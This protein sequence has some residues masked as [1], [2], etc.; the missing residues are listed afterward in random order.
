MINL[1]KYLLVLF[2]IALL[3]CCSTPLLVPADPD[4]FRAKAKWADSDLESLKKGYAIYT[5]KCGSCHD[6]KHPDKISS[7]EWENVFPPMALK[8]HLTEQEKTLVYRYFV[9]MH[10]A[11]AKK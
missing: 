7:A 6:L 9:T 11:V 3:A 8:A 4:A 5:N 10:D 1:K 2:G